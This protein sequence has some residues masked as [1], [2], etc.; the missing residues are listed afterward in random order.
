VCEKEAR[1]ID[2]IR[3]KRR[4]FNENVQKIREVFPLYFDCG[5]SLDDDDLSNLCVIFTTCN[6]PWFPLTNVC[7]CVCV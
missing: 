4:R 2:K 3:D 5:G 7:M 1:K 6:V